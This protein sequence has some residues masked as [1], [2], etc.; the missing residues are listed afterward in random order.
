MRPLLRDRVE[1]LRVQRDAQGRSRVRRIVTS[2]RR[3]ALRS[4]E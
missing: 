1:A 4:A 3:R 2:P